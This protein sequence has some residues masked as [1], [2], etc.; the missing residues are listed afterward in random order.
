MEERRIARAVE[1]GFAARGYVL[2]ADTTRAD[3]VLVARAGAWQDVH[4]EAQPYGPLRGRSARLE[5]EAR[6][7]LWVQVYDRRTGRLAWHGVVADALASDP[8]QADKRTARAVAKLL[9]HFP[10][11]GGAR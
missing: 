1:A 5:R 2:A 10:A 4:V 11:R 8:A 6:G 3:F 9:A 7:A